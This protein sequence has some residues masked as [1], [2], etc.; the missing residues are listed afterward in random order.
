MGELWIERDPLLGV[1]VH[2]G[3]DK[4]QAALASKRAP[5]ASG[6]PVRRAWNMNTS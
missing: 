5:P 1:V 6:S 3:S 4:D 2:S